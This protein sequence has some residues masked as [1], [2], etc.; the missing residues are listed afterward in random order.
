MV[1]SMNTWTLRTHRYLPPPD[2]LQGQYLIAAFL[3][4][5]APPYLLRQQQPLPT[6]SGRTTIAR[7]DA[8]RQKPVVWNT[9]R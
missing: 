7:S 5:N 2:V 3:H 1:S 8:R 9:G 4:C 6:V